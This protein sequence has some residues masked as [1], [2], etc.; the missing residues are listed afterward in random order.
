MRVIKKI[1]NNVAVCQDGNGQEL[2]ALG[3]GIGFPKTPY[4]LTDLSKIDMTFYRVSSQ[5]IDLLKEIPSEVLAVSAHIVQLARQ[6]S[7]SNLSSNVVF[8]LAD[9]I[10][11]AIERVKKGLT[12]DFSLTYDIEHL[13]SNEYAI[14]QIALKLIQEDLNVSLPN[15]EATAIAMHFINAAEISGEK[16]DK[17]SND[18]LLQMVITKIESHFDITINRKSFAFNRF[19]IHFQYYLQRL[20]DNK[21][22]SGEI[23]SSLI[24]DFSTNKKSVYKCGQDIVVTIDQQLHTQTTDDE[25]FYLMIYINRM[26]SKTIAE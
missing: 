22:I 13:Y 9:H 10:N 14:G 26:I 6:K 20:Q 8:S 17:N 2:I 11:F 16:I 7:N 3:K 5:M 12:F 15:E 21:Q 19:K 24:K 4:E 18:N 1:N 23:T 25:M